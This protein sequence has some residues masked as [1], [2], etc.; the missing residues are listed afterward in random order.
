M[1]KKHKG[2]I[3]MCLVVYL[4]TLVWVILFHTTLETLNHLCDP[5]WRSIDFTLSFNGRETLLNVLLFIPFGLFL[6]ALC[7]KT[8]LARKIGIIAAVPLFFEI[9]QYIFSMGSS[10]LM[11][12]ISNSIGGVVGLAV[13]HAM[14]K[15]LKDR[16]YPVVLGASVLGTLLIVAI[17]LFVPLR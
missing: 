11:D 2:I 7:E 10:T 9:A 14:R 15:L 8:S 3:G 13:C 6:G 5:F 12:V 16:F 4:L 17:V 1:V